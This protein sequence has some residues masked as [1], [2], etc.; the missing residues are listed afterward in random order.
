MNTLILLMLEKTLS[1]QATGRKVKLPKLT[2]RQRGLIC[3]HPKEM[4]LNSLTALCQSVR[5]DWSTIN[6]SAEAYL[7][8]IEAIRDLDDRID[9]ITGVTAI[10]YF[11][12]FATSWRGPVAD[13]VKRQFE[14][15]VEAH[16]A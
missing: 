11:L 2:S 1:G 7:Q 10:A 8:R 13:E 3:N 15:L 14:C 5:K 12:T 9:G 6:P 4:A 16:Y